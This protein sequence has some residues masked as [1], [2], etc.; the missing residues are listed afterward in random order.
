MRELGGALRNWD[1]K[2]FGFVVVV[3]AGILLFA[4][5]FVPVAFGQ[6]TTGT[7]TG[8]IT[9][10]KGAAMSGV[11]V[12]VHNADTGLDTPVRTN[13][14]GIYTATTLQP[15]NYDV[16]AAQTGFSSVQNKGVRVQVGD[17]V[18]IDIEMPV[19]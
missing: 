11:A 13:D 5:S 6:T 18:R 10:A 3:C 1:P 8:T 7:I 4:T 17:T 2:K 12:T 19:A 15:G 16:T 9:D 14:S